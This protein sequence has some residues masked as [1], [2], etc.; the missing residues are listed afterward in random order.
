MRTEKEKMLGGELYDPNAP[1][2]QE[3]LAASDIDVRLLVLDAPDAICMYWSTVPAACCF[4]SGAQC[5]T[6]KHCA[7]TASSALS[8]EP[9][10]VPLRPA[11]DPP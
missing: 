7:P 2:I 5:S 11:A 1:E 9:E 10:L 8:F 3:E 4:A 6:S